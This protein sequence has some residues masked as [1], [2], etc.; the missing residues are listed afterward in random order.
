VSE[1]DA[2]LPVEPAELGF[3][4]IRSEKTPPPATITLDRP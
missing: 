4:R 1:P 2:P 3:E